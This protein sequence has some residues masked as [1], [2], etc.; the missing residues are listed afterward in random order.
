MEFV[1]PAEAGYTARNGTRCDGAYVAFML[2]SGVNDGGIASACWGYSG[3]PGL[4]FSFVVR[5]FD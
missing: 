3:C 5:L 4:M 2:D 1:R